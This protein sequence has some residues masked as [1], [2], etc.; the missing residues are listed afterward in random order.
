MCVAEYDKA[1]RLKNGTKIAIKKHEYYENNK[2]DILEKSTTYYQEHKEEKLIYQKQFAQDNKEKIA[3]TQKEYR[4]NNKDLIKMRKKAREEADPSIKEKRK[5]YKK[6][7]DKEN[8]EENKAK[9]KAKYQE[10][11]EQRQLAS[12]EYY[13]INKDK[14]AIK[15]HEYY[16]NNKDE[17]IEN[18]KIY[19]RNNKDKLRIYRQ[20]YDN[21][22]RAND[23][24][25]KIKCAI[26]ANINFHIKKN[27]GSKQRKSCLDFLPYSMEE[28]IQH[29]VKQFQLPG[30]EWMTIEN[31]GIY[32]LET[33]DDNDP[34]TWKWHLDHI[35]PQSDLPYSSMED[36][37]FK[38]CWAL[39]NLRPYSAKQNILDGVNR[40]RHQKIG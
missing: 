28:L 37:N 26:S 39:E 15:K 14:I 32:D 18:V 33:W 21:N 19:A 5:I 8:E 35:I 36:E 12:K 30:N 24:S 9:R 27:G 3:I 20:K 7:Y 10:N 13:F 38:K 29:L 1:Y 11:K 25:F 4:T 16:E 2:D 31:H 6:Q 17:I 40:T 34:Q 23:P 22:K